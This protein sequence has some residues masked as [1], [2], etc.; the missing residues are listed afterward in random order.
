MRAWGVTY[1]TGFT[2]CG[3]TTH[4][5]FDPVVVAEDMRI[6]RDELHAD[7]VRITGGVPDRLE[8]AA[9]HAAAVGLEVW[10]CPF[11]HD[12]TTDELLEFLLD[13]A[14]RAE[15][16][17]REGADI[18]LLTG[19]EISIMTIGLMPGRTLAER[20][21][22]LTDPARVRDV[23]P[24]VQRRTNA[25]LA[26]A[27]DGARERF[28]G[29]IGYA[30]LP[31]EGV[32]WTPFDFIATDAGYRDAGNAAALPANLATMTSL[33]T[34]FAVTEF[35]CAPFTGAA[36]RGSRGDIVAYDDQSGQATHLTETVERNE[37]EQ[38]AYLLD[39]L[40]VYDSGGVDT[41]FVYT[42]ASRHLPTS[43]HPEQDFDL[44]S[45][46]IVTI[47]PDGRT[48]NAY[49]GMPWEPKAAFTALAEYG[50]LRAGEPVA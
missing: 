44:G 29:L 10:Y 43:E 27:V 36:D 25:L 1:D 8:T 22:V 42:F 38:A 5:P 13:A 47:L 37:P 50:R 46:G 23:L 11:T 7:A 12:L 16:I 40:D 15:R 34:P 28:G 4:E 39:L 33:G 41:A 21:A 31:M 18:R 2:H 49:P 24:G 20:S 30:S 3:S 9:R 48:G 45:F 32:D 26:R 6:I 19:S 14:E 17:R 35:G